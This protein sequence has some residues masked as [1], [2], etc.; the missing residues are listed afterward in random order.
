MS[1]EENGIE[2]YKEQLD[3]FTAQI[4]KLS[5]ITEL[6]ASGKFFFYHPKINVEDDH[7]ILLLV[8]NFNQ[9][10]ANIKEYQENLEEKVQERTKELEEKNKELSELFEKVNDLKK[11]QDGDYFL[12][13]LLLEP[14]GQNKSEQNNVKIEFLIQQ[15]KRFTFKNKEHSIGGDICGANTIKLRGKKHT[16]FF[17][18]DA[19]GKSI[20]GAGGALVLGALFEAIINRTQQSEKIQ[21]S[22]PEIWI[23]DS[24][25]EI[26]TVFESFDGLMLMSLLVGLIDN[27][28]GLVYTVSFDY[29]TPVLYRGREASYIMQYSYFSKIG[30]AS[31][32]FLF[33]GNETNEGLPLY[34]N[35]F[36]LQDGDSLF[37]GSDGKDDLFLGQDGLNNRIINSDD[38]LFL[39][40]IKNSH[41]EL[42]EIY[43]TLKKNGEFIDDVSLMKV[44]YKRPFEKKTIVMNAHTK[45]ALAVFKNFFLERAY[46]KAEK[47]IV[48]AYKLGYTNPKVFKYLAKV[49]YELKLYKRAAYF[50]KYYYKLKPIDSDN[51]K[52]LADSYKKLGKIEEAVE[53]S[54]VLIFR[55]RNV[56]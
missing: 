54:A 20:Q 10:V 42:K 13:S 24:I 50:A 36:N 41:G 56:P 52:I 47:E 45:K 23:R 31:D 29:P 40:V 30:I 6:I 11:Q 17:A 33:D 43:N 15:K 53:L 27:Q 8:K 19:M 14:L 34:I 32:F 26:Q 44:S 9:M 28:T 22:Y 51:I 21:N 46:K 12:T 48:K 37:A 25:T 3:L 4:S 38:N 5:K 7:P 18:A 16:V 49:Y 39:R 2:S 1:S 55:L 35:L